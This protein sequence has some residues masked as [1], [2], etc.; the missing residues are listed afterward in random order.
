MRT[1]LSSLILLWS[2]SVFAVDQDFTLQELNTVQHLPD[3]LRVQ[4]LIFQMAWQPFGQNLQ[5]NDLGR[6][7]AEVMNIDG[8]RD[9]E[10]VLALPYEPIAL[11]ED[12][13][14]QSVEAFWESAK[15]TFDTLCTT[16][17]NAFAQYFYGAFL[18]KSYA[19]EG[20]NTKAASQLKRASDQYYVRAS[21]FILTND[22]LIAEAQT[23]KQDLKEKIRTVID[24][25]KLIAKFIKRHP[26][27]GGIDW[28]DIHRLEDSLNYLPGD[29]KIYKSIYANLAK[30]LSKS[31]QTHKEKEVD[32]RLIGPVIVGALTI[33]I[34][35]VLQGASDSFNG[36]GNLAL[37]YTCAN[38]THTLY[39]PSSSTPALTQTLG[40]VG[41]ANGGAGLIV[42][43]LGYP[44]T[45]NFIYSFN[46]ESIS[47]SSW[48]PIKRSR[49]F[50]SSFSEDE[51]SKQSH[52]VALWAV[53]YNKLTI[54]KDIAGWLGYYLY[55]RKLR[56]LILSSY[57]VERI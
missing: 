1:I 55:A 32:T 24:P 40:S 35:S 7:V 29:Y 28:G 20:D 16:N 10:Q 33:G 5:E 43:L 36:T 47:R 38:T 26:S 34:S 13:A 49:L 22:T 37:N 3:R 41:I 45:S 51:I 44:M 25:C 2:V 46:V 48:R 21:Q 52:V 30:E 56:K 12:I 53:L 11:S 42:T 19:Q 54:Q 4:A 15:N 27:N 57:E 50:P 23:T 14:P 8:P 18:S 6:Y 9:N 31:L 39:I 17:N